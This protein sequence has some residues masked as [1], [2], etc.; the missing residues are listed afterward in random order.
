MLGR[1]A[2]A[3]L[4]KGQRGLHCWDT[5]SMLWDRA[6]HYGSS[7]SLA[8]PVK[9]GKSP[10]MTE[11]VLN[12]SSDYGFCESGCVCINWTWLLAAG[13]PGHNHGAFT[14]FQLCHYRN[15]YG[16]SLSTL[17][18]THSGWSSQC[19]ITLRE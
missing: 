14:D 2:Q 6:Q 11:G 1:Q 9:A 5:H 17:L 15:Y 16:D 18:Q 3:G 8:S 10:G 12:S 13:F 7:Q 4:G 19:V